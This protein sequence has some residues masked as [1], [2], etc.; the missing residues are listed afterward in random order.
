MPHIVD[1]YN[2]NIFRKLPNDIIMNIIKIRTEED[3]MLR[4]KKYYSKCVLHQLNCLHE[5]ENKNW[6]YSAWMK[7]S[8]KYKLDWVN[9]L[10]KG[11]PREPLPS[12]Y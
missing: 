10:Y 3:K 7:I 2:Q 6:F 8:L 9:K 5:A 1:Y 11:E 4:K 12:C